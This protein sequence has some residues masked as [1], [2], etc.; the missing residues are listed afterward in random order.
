MTQDY[1]KIAFGFKSS[2][3]EI[4]FLDEDK[5]EL[6]TATPSNTDFKDEVGFLLSSGHFVMLPSLDAILNVSKISKIEFSNDNLNIYNN[7]GTLI[8]ALPC[9]SDQ[10][11]RAVYGLIKQCPQFWRVPKNLT[12][13]PFSQIKDVI[14]QE[15]EDP[16]D[17]GTLY[18]EIY[19]GEVFE[20]NDLSLRD[21][22]APLEKI[23]QRIRLNAEFRGQFNNAVNAEAEKKQKQHKQEKQEMLDDPKVLSKLSGSIKKKVFGQDHAV[24]SVINSVLISKAGLHDDDKPIGSF[25]FTGPTGVGKTELAKTLAQELGMEFT[26]LDMS[27]YM[28]KVAVSRM[29]G[30]SPNYVGYEEGGVLTNFV[31]EHPDS[32]ILF[33]EIEKAHPDVANLLLQVMDNAAMTDGQGEVVNFNNCIIIMTSNL[34]VRDHEKQLGFGAI[35][36]ESAQ[37]QGP[38]DLDGR[39]DKAVK[40]HFLPEFINR[41]DSVIKFKHLTKAIM[42]DLV[43]KFLRELSDHLVEKDV[44]LDVNKEAKAFLA[45]KGYDRLYGARPLKRVIHQ[46]M[47]KP[48]SRSILFGALQNGGKAKV[49]VNAKGDLH[50][51]FRKNAPK[52]SVKKTADKDTPATQKKIKTKRSAPRNKQ[53][54]PS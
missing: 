44:V 41:V 4:Y 21:L 1:T 15:E 39:D 11:T 8:K 33:D 19:N 51:T 47:K 53:N 13:F 45:D 25:L 46:H 52:K 6:F 10:A 5:K 34:G 38:K 42:V 40:N 35:G 27:E 36:Q 49:S 28:E 14:H 31:M 50:H 22:G 48:L 2:D 12:L 18:V 54:Q 32:V 23:E 30:G 43:G 7:E 17:K 9:D 16:K 29:I 37:S 20:Y 24:D 26:R 3:D